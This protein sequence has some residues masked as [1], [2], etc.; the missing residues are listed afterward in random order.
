MFQK[1]QVIYSE[2]LGACVVDNIVPLSA[3]RTEPA[4]LYYVLKCLFE[5]KVSYKPVEHHQDRLREMFTAEEA[6]K[7]KESEEA[8]KDG[9]LMAAIKYVL[10]TEQED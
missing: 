3:S 2:S 1:K 4:V 7:L 8:Q 9:H 6:E 10:N 5:D